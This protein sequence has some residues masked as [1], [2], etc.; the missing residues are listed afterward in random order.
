MTADQLKIIIDDTSDK[1]SKCLR[2]YVRRETRHSDAISLEVWRDGAGVL[3]IARRSLNHPNSFSGCQLSHAMQRG[4][5]SQNWCYISTKGWKVV[6][7]FWRDY[8]R[9]GVCALDP[10]HLWYDTRW[11][12]KGKRRT[13]R[14]CGLKQ[15]LTTIREIIRTDCWVNI[16]TADK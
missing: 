16:K 3:H 11:Q 12:V 8:I 9:I 4:R 10:A 14:H 7:H 2:E 13:C 15:R 5:R 1:Y 6:K